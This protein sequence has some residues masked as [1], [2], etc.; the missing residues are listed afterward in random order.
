[1]ASKVF[2]DTNI[3]IDFIQPIRAEHAAAKQLFFELAENN[4]LA[5]FSESV[6]TALA[7]ILRKDFKPSVLI[8]IIESLNTQ[9]SLLPSSNSIIKTAL[10]N[11][12]KDIE[13]AI[14]YQTAMEN[15]LNY[16]ITSNKKDFKQIE[17][18]K[19]PVISAKEFLT[20]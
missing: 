7:Y 4:F 6:V 18:R 12:P 13:D 9:I 16:F 19:L 8:T 15:N 11:N 20:I 10:L 2:F 17:K 14:L 1:M 5:Y 3:I